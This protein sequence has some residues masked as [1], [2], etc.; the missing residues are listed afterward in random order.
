MDHRASRAKCQAGGGP[1]ERRVRPHSPAGDCAGNV[2]DTPERN[3]GSDLLRSLSLR[4]RNCTIFAEFERAK[5]RCEGI[6]EVP[7]E[8]E[9]LTRSARDQ[10]AR[11]QL[12]IKLELRLARQLR[13]E[14]E[15][16]SF[17]KR[18]YRRKPKQKPVQSFMVITVEEHELP[19]G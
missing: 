15:G 19:L 3:A 11:Y 2:E 4:P 17:A 8:E 5:A 7:K 6:D 13:V 9:V 1:L 12:A 10:P 14:V 16:R 18:G